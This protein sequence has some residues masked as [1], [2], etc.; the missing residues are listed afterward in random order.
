MTQGS[1]TNHKP[2]CAVLTPPARGAVATIGVRGRGAASAVAQRFC[3]ASGQPLESFSTGRVVFGRFRL[4]A[5]AN[6]ELVVGLVGPDRVEVHCH[7]GRAAVMAIASALVEEG[8]RITDAA[9]WMAGEQPDPLAA[10]ALLALGHARTE[11]TAA[12]LL[13]QF[14]GALRAATEEIT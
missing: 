10:A 11:R 12:V 9:E 13:D 6:E 7:G 1:M 4:A 5:G 2:V 8:C 14:R 3:P